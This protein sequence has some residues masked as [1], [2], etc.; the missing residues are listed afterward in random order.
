MR[1]RY[2]IYKQNRREGW[3]GGGAGG[4]P[5]YVAVSKPAQVRTELRKEARTPRV[6]YATSDMPSRKP[7]LSSVARTSSRG[8]RLPSSVKASR[9]WYDF[10]PGMW[11]PYAA[12]EG[13]AVRGGRVR[14]YAWSTCMDVVRRKLGQCHGEVVG[15]NTDAGFLYRVD[16]DVLLVSSGRG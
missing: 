10:A 6:Q 12:G 8:R 2:R 9:Q 14:L 15:V 16:V 11:P 4:A 13:A 5:A 1:S 3:A 7:R